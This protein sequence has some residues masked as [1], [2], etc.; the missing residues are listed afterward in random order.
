MFKKTMIIIG[1]SLILFFLFNSKREKPLPPFDSSEFSGVC[2]NVTDNVNKEQLDSYFF[3]Y[4]KYSNKQLQSNIIPIK[5][6]RHQ[7][8]NLQMSDKLNYSLEDTGNNT[9]II[10]DKYL[11]K[12]EILNLV[13]ENA[14]LSDK[15]AVDNFRWQELNKYC[16]NL[17]GKNYSEIYSLMKSSEQVINWSW[18]RRGE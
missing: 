8:I 17:G 16:L 9:L 18:M 14:W 7:E 11:T 15:I 12:E 4:E 10:L 5:L 13:S 1:F 3:N 6:T 2:M